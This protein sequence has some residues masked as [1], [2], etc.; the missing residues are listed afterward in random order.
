[1]CTPQSINCNNLSRK[2]TNGQSQTASRFQKVK[3]DAC[4]SS[5]LGKCITPPHLSWTEKKSQSL[6]IS[7]S[8]ASLSIKKI[9]FIPHLLYPTQKGIKIPPCKNPLIRSKINYGYF[10][11]G[12][13]GKSNQ[14]SL[15]TIQHEGLKLV[16]GTF[17]NPQWRGSP[18][19]MNHLSYQIPKI[20]PPILH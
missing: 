12:S 5:K 17:R 13:A 3:Q 1:M 4:I 20:R 8:S 9:T 11:H 10:M 7:K 14:K 19:L 16:L 2:S 18:R 6:I 15:N